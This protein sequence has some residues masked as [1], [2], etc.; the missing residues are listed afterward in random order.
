MKKWARARKCSYLPARILSFYLGN[1]QQQQ[2]RRRHTYDNDEII[3]HK[4]FHPERAPNWAA[5]LRPHCQRRAVIWGNRSSGR[6]E[7]ERVNTR[8]IWFVEVKILYTHG[9]IP[10]LSRNERRVMSV[11]LSDG[12]TKHCAAVWWCCV[13]EK[14]KRKR[15]IRKQVNW[16]RCGDVVI[17]THI[18]FSCDSILSAS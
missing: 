13:D 17:H 4:L 12:S 18:R 1:E 2:K 15:S 5:E 14:K 9:P 7:S 16:N 3:E 8:S 6:Q 11:L 10:T